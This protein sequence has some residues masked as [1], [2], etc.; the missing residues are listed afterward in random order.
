MIVRWPGRIRP[1][2]TTEQVAI[3]MDW[4]PTLLEI[5]GA[6]PD[7]SYPP[8]GISLLPMLIQNSV[9]IPR[10]LFWRYKANAQRAIRDGDMKWLKIENNDFLFNVVADPLE[11][12]N[13]KN[14]LPD[15]HK[16]LVSEYEGWNA[17]VL[18]D[19]AAVSSATRTGAKWA[20][21]YGNR[22]RQQ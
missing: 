9:P 22:S 3:S 17:G 21:H 15:V 11:R 14:R 6:A 20:D 10:K 5:A 19:D 18:S 7:P 8:D 4:F 12:A 16:R 1:G 13:L 2:S